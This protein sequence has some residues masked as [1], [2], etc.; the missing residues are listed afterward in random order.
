MNSDDT[1]DNQDFCSILEMHLYDDRQSIGCNRKQIS[2]HKFWFLFYFKSENI[3]FA[4]SLSAVPAKKYRMVLLLPR[5]CKILELLELFKGTSDVAASVQ[6]LRSDTRNR[7]SWLKH[8][9]RWCS[10]INSQIGFT[11]GF[12]Y[13]LLVRNKY[14]NTYIWFLRVLLDNLESFNFNRIYSD[15]YVKISS[16]GVRSY[17]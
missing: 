3:S 9:K 13:L 16:N 10:W 11:V 17:V 1:D 15:F 14:W 6:M 12:Y 2:K 8:I 4:Y 5:K 7:N